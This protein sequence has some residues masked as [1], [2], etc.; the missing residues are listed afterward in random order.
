[1]GATDREAAETHRGHFD[2]NE[3]TECFKFWRRVTVVRSGQHFYLFLRVPRLQY[4]ARVD[5]TSQG[6]TT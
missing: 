3:A 5:R 4:S 2:F 6:M 1:M